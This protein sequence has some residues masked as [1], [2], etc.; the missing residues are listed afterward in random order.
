MTYHFYYLS[1]AT[2]L[3]SANTKL[4]TLAPGLRPE[5]RLAP[6]ARGLLFSMTFLSY[7]YVLRIY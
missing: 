3:N 2:T 1:R 7:G 4:V 5:R 6:L